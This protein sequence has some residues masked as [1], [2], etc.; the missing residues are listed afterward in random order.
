VSDPSPPR[1]VLDS[2]IIFSRVLHELTGRVAKRM[3]VLDLVWSD[4]LL[5]EAKKKLIRR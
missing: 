2:D 4:E 5:N 3:R 1:V